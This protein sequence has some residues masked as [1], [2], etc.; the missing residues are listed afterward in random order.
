MG[1]VAIPEGWQEATIEQCFTFL[2]TA[3]FSRKNMHVESSNAYYIHYGDIHRA[4]NR[5][6]DFSKDTVFRLHKDCKITKYDLLTDGDLIVAD[7][8]EDYAGI[9]VSCEIKNLKEKAISGLH[10]FALRP[11]TSKISAGYALLLVQNKHTKRHL[12]IM[13]TGISVL[14]IS[15]HNIRN[16]PIY[17]PP[18]AEQKA[19]ASLLQTWDAAIEKTDALIA[20]KEQQF[21]WLIAH[22]VHNQHEHL[23]KLKNHFGVDIIIEKGKPLVKNNRIEGDIPV[24][25][26]G[27]SSPYNHNKYTHA[28]PCITIS[29]SGAYAGFV[30]YH[31]YPIW[32]SDCNVI[33]SKKHSIQY[34][35]FA[36]KSKQL[37]I[38]AF[39]IGSAQPHVYARDIQ[40]ISI[41]LPPLSEQKRIAHTLNTAQKEIDLLKALVKKYR[42]QKRG[43]MQKLLTGI[44]R[45]KICT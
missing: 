4:S 20:A 11:H 43:L 37:Q 9:A 31:H 19:I 2:K 32:A 18:L 27:R 40:N 29:A 5:M 35:F 26:G 3:S 6:V 25:A 36:L 14:G 33:F 30:Q 7:A 28:M 38:H 16:T 12:R 1:N 45:V 23:E 15:K 10:T 8:S 39:K 41:P 34:L 24:I 17:L 44:W 42:I 21:E 22:L 13:A